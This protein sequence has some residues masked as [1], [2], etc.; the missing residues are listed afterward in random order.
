MSWRWVLVRVLLTLAVFCAAPLWLVPEP[1]TQLIGDVDNTQSFGV[2]PIELALVEKLG[3][4]TA[5]NSCSHRDLGFTGK[6]GGN[7]YSVWADTLWAAPGIVDPERDTPG[8]HGMVRSS[9]SLLTD[10]PLQVVDLNLNNDW[11]VPH[12]QPF[13]PFNED[14]GE[15]SRTAFGGASL[16]EVDGESATAAVYILVNAFE[17]DLV[18][19]GVAKVQVVNGTPT[20]TQ[21]F[22]PK[23]YWWDATTTPHYGDKF[24]YRDERSDYIY[25]WGGPPNRYTG[26]L[27]GGYI[28]LARVKAADAFD[29]CKYEYWW[30]CQ[31]GWKPEVLT[32]FTTETA[33][34][35]GTGQGQIV[36]NEYY[37][38]Y[39]M[40]HL[41]IA[42]VT[43]YMRTAKSLEGPWTPD[44]EI[45]TTTPIDDGLVYAGVA[46]PYLDSSGKS[47]VVSFTN[48]NR[49]EVV[50]AWFK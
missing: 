2:N 24:S 39:I 36:W 11:P 30:G 48:N 42:G 15:S 12:Q 13:I 31:Q 21:R 50:K 46:H 10:D 14:W 9:V 20:V 32:T 17:P 19:A 28:Y 5:C 4:Q 25:I 26:W 7:W 47:L 8:F 41:G 34:L 35:W 27:E 45:Y 49:I 37:G 38:C 3:Y 1:V 44:L 6:V 29:L 40:V 43:L 33:A 16:C 22:G 23:G 18:G